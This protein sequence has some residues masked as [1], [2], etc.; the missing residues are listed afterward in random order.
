MT[1]FTVHETGQIIRERDGAWIPP[2]P[3]NADYQEYLAWQA[4]GG[5]FP[6]RPPLDL[7]PPDARSPPD[8]G[9]PP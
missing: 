5:A 2:D 3:A 9:S 6:E 4:N 7:T 8:N 1:D